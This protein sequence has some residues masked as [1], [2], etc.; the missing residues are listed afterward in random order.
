MNIQEMHE[1]ISVGGETVLLPYDDI[2]PDNHAKMKSVQQL[3]TL[4]NEY[5]YPNFLLFFLKFTKQKILM[6]TNG[7][8]LE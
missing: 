2:W 6:T 1:C 4:K 3:I 5:T 8:L 7:R